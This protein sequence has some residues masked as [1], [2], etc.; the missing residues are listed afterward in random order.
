M[1]TRPATAPTVRGL[2]PEMTF[3]VD[4][5]LGE[6]PQR[7]R[8]IFADPFREDDQRARDQFRGQPGGAITG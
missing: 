6:I 2:S 4:A 1:P 5:L 8:G 7:F 3:S